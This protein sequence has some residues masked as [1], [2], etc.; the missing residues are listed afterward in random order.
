VTDSG[1]GVE[2]SPEIPLP[3]PAVPVPT[4]TRRER[5]RHG[6]HRVRLYSWTMLL[7]AA[8]IV[9]VGLIVDNTR[10]VKIGW[11]FGGTH[12]SLVWVILTAAIVG[13]LAGLATSVVL[14]R[15]TRRASGP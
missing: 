13:W 12:T 1:G 10:Q 4:A 9:I 15:R 14:R 3:G 6:A 7:V 8:F 2:P 5:L 11:V